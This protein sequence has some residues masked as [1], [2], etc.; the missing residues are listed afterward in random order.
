[1]D[2]IFYL[3]LL[4]GV[5]FGGVL[6]NLTL[7]AAS[8]WRRK[9]PPGPRR[10]PII[11]NAHQVPKDQPWETFGTW[12]K[13]YGNMVYLDLMGQPAVVLNSRQLAS[14]LLDKRSAIYS[15]RPVLEMASLCGYSNLMVLSQY[16]EGWKQQRK[17]ACREFL[18]TTV[19]KHFPFQEKVM[20]ELVRS[21]VADPSSIRKEIAYRMGVVIM[22][23][24]YGYALTGKD[25]HFLQ[26]A[27]EAVD[28]FKGISN[29]G[30]W[31]V[32]VIPAMKHLPRW[33]P[34]TSFF[35]TAERYSKDLMSACFDPFRWAQAN[36]AT[37]HS[38]LPNL[39]G[40]MLDEGTLSASDAKI[41]PWSALSMFGGALDTNV[42]TVMSFLLFMIHNPDI[43]AK[44]QA[45]LDK[46]VGKH[47]LPSIT[48]RPDLPYLR[49]VITES[50]RVGCP[51]P[52]CVP[53]ALSRDDEYNGYFL[54]KGTWILPNIW[55][56]CHDPA[57]YPDPFVFRPERY[58]NDDAEMEK[59]K[60]VVFG[61]GRRVCAG[62]DF[63]E[64]GIFVIAATLLATCDILPGLDENANV[65]MPEIAFT[66]GSIREPK[67]FTTR[68]KP[69]SSEAASLLAE[70]SS[71]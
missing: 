66:N 26:N 8:R 3:S 63:G 12:S 2:S 33:V 40:D 23:M 34:G 50:L 36:L 70:I 28:N 45:E 46:V 68:F 57:D 44:V 42:G 41:L 9:Y 10:L 69:R 4:A 64:S 38:L 71:D 43:Q 27:V 6:V 16:G 11:G 22:R 53:H 67:P 29:P 58:N 24:T 15:D 32:D 14:E 31:L 52:L 39:V 17:I 59:L 20:R 47:R 37:G 18:P 19:K 25:D 61:F 13:S 60:S 54:S 55:Q 35:R 1:M 30:Q 49:S 7:G 56:M 62:R 21:I 51:P 48:D 5:V 65:V